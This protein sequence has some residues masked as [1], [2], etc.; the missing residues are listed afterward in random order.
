MNP[1][2]GQRVSLHEVTRSHKEMRS[3]L[4]KCQSSQNWPQLD[5][6]ER[7]TNRSRPDPLLSQWSSGIHR[8]CL[9]DWL[10]PVYILFLFASMNG[11]QNDICYSLYHTKCKGPSCHSGLTAR[12]GKNS[13]LGFPDRVPENNKR[14]EN[15]T[16][17]LTWPLTGIP[18]ENGDPVIKPRSHHF[19]PPTPSEILHLM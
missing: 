18:P 10:V 13:L 5:S 3:Y 4:H 1:P 7:I 9:A 14:R 11:S 12:M 19:P 8:M 2:S 6:G 17:W 15:E 16:V